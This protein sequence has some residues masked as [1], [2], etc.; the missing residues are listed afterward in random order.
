MAGSGTSYWDGIISW[1]K[2]DN[3]IAEWLTAEEIQCLKNL[4]D[5]TLEIWKAATQYQ[6]FDVKLILRNMRKNY[7]IT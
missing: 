3:S 2:E 6:G 5:E 1:L 4:N 7:I